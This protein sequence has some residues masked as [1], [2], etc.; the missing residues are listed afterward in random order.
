MENR[1]HKIV[2]EAENL[3]RKMFSDIDEQQAKAYN[4]RKDFLA[5]INTFSAW[6]KMW[7]KYNRNRIYAISS[8]AVIILLVSLIIFL[9]STDKQDNYLVFSQI[10]KP[11]SGDVILKLSDGSSLQIDTVKRLEGNL[12]GVDIDNLSGEISYA[13]ID[14]RKDSIIQDY[15]SK[16]TRTVLTERKRRETA[17]EFNELYIPKGRSYTLVLNDGTRV[18]LN[19]E[20]FIRYPVRFGPRE[21]KVYITGEAFFDVKS[22]ASRHFI[23][24]TNAYDIQVLGTRFNINSYEEENTVATTLVSGSVLIDSKDG[25][26]MSISPGE[27]FRLDKNDKSISVSKVDVGLYTSWID[28]ILQINSMT[29]DDIF[30]ILKRRYDIEVNYIH[31]KAKTER[32]SG[33]IPLND[34]LNVILTQISKVSELEFNIEDKTIMVKYK[35]I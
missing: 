21:R 16:E 12:H 2:E 27:Q 1:Y 26:K 11:A 7:F 25:T 28:N 17:M 18:W 4:E 34:N 20:S 5:E 32:F 19:S 29:L 22:D 8:A 23:V 14:V 9:P 10:V 13:Y 35:K 6:R 31:L 33:R 15:S 3:S 24:S 30:K